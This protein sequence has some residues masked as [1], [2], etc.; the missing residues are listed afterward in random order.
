MQSSLPAPKVEQA[1]GG[2]RLTSPGPPDNRGAAD[3]AFYSFGAVPFEPLAYDTPVL[4]AA[5]VEV[6]NHGANDAAFY[7]F[8]T[9]PFE[10]LAYVPAPDPEPQQATQGVENQGAADAGFYSFGMPF[11][12]L[13]YESAAA[14]AAEV[15]NRG[16][17][18]AAFYSFGSAPF[19]PLAYEVPTRKVTEAIDSS[20][21][22]AADAAFYSFGTVPFEPLAYVPAQASGEGSGGMNKVDSGVF[23]VPSL[24]TNLKPYAPKVTAAKPKKRPLSAHL[25]NL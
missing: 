25:P 15:G 7:S 8:G 12:P 11:E 21:R 23:E 9:V 6:G 19:E 22:A 5:A 17:A 24:P 2:N 3:A 10:P 16:A 14:S 13:A 20:D 18:D 1:L 4:V